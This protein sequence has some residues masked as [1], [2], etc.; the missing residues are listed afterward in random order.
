[1]P[2]GATE[3]VPVDLGVELIIVQG[4]PDRADLVGPSEATTGPGHLEAGPEGLGQLIG[5]QL[6]QHVD[7]TGIRPERRCCQFE[8]HR[9]VSTSH[10]RTL[11][12]IFLGA[13]CTYRQGSTSGATGTTPSRLGVELG[14]GGGNDAAQEEVTPETFTGPSNNG[15]TGDVYI[16]PVTS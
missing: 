10:S 16:T 11:P 15:G 4:D 7:V 13:T 14:G 3:G 12:P 2:D 5:Q 9:I 8:V 1:M 6:D